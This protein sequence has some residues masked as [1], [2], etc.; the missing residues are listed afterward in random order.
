MGTFKRNEHLFLVGHTDW[1][2]G[3]FCTQ[4]TVQLMVT[5]MEHR[6]TALLQQPQ[7]L[8]YNLNMF[9]GHRKDVSVVFKY[10]S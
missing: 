10:T 8:K 3:N 4:A 7:C 2:F 5:N 1:S 9:L 6:H